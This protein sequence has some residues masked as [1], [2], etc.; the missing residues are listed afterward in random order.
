[1]KDVALSTGKFP[2]GIYTLEIQLVDPVCPTGGDTKEIK[3]DLT[4]PSRVELRSPR[5]GE[6][7]SEFP[8]FEFYSDGH[9]VTLTVTEIAAGQSREDAIGN[10]PPMLETELQ[11][12]NAFLYAGGRP[13]ERGKSYAWRVKTTA[14]TSG[15]SGADIVSPV[16]TFTV[17][18]TPGEGTA[19]TEDAILR[20]LE[21]LFGQRYPSLFESIRKGK[22]SPDGTYSLNQSALTESQLLDLLVQLRDM[23]DSVDLTLE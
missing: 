23:S 7:T 13:L 5:D 4:N 8:L 18:A 12:Q 14:R 11:S 17:A 9:P 2:A 10:Q 1:V 22:L 15:G 21:E 3:F 6:V 20:Q 19:S 16:G